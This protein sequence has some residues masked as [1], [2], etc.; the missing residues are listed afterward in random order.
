MDI[1]QEISARLGIDTSQAQSGV[2][3]IFGAIQ[4]AAPA[5]DFQALMAKVPEAATWIRSIPAAAL[6]GGAPASAAVSTGFGGLLGDAAGG[7][8][9]AAGSALGGA[10]GA[11]GSL[12]QAAEGASALA[13]VVSMLGKLGIPAETAMKMLPMVAE[14]LQSRAGSVLPQLAENVPFLKDV[15]GP[16]GAAGGL[17]GILGRM[18]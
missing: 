4:Q 6:G 7:F 5:A 9:G 3:A 2:G 16:G 12:G 10:G 14:F 8:L 15:L 11:L 17:S 18:V 1:I 13:G